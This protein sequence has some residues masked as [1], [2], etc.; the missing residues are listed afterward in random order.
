MAAK[1]VDFA[2]LAASLRPDTVAS[3]NAFRRR[4]TD[5]VKQIADLKEQATTINFEGYRSILSNKKVV[6]DAE[7]AFAAFKP[8]QY[9]LR[10]QLRVIEAQEIKAVA[11]AEATEKR[12]TQELVELKELLVNID[13]ARPVDQ[14]TIDDVVKAVPEIDATVEKMIKRGQWRMPGY[15]EKFGEFN[16]GF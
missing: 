12:I 10:E 14:L 9:D 15:Y 16:V 13:T 2:K 4:H 5:L 1:R 8:A 3:L 7:K 6:N 11:A